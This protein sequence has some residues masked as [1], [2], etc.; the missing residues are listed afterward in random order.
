MRC[1]LKSLAAGILAASLFFFFLMML[2]LPISALLARLA[3]HARQP[4]MLVDPTLIFRHFG[5]PLSAAVFLVTLVLVLRRLR[6]RRPSAAPEA[7][8]L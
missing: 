2:V 5:L 1:F 7:N 4:D 3:R 6:T 8:L